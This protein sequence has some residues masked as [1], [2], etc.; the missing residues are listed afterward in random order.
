MLRNDV[1]TSQLLKARGAA[2]RY[3]SDRH[4]ANFIGSDLARPAE[5]EASGIEGYY[6]PAFLSELVGGPSQAEFL[7]L[8]LIGSAGAGECENVQDFGLVRQ[9]DTDFVVAVPFDYRDLLALRAGFVLCLGEKRTT[10][11]ER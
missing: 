9:V 6:F 11:S 8:H 2:L 7:I 5:N 1:H 4:G 10:N 3:P